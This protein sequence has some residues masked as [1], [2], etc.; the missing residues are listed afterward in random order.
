MNVREWSND[1]SNKTLRSVITLTGS[2]SAV[3]IL[4]AIVFAFGP[5]PIAAARQAK[6]KIGDS[7]PILKQKVKWRQKRPTLGEEGEEDPS[8][9][10]AQS[11][12][13]EKAEQPKRSFQERLSAAFLHTHRRHDSAISGAGVTSQS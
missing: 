7:Y 8:P 2:I 12:L 3:I 6:E 13:S 10:R 9:V 5:P 4:I 1:D 11:E